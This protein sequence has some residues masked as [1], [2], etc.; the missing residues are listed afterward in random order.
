M[1]EVAPSFPVEAPLGHG[2]M[3]ELQQAILGA[4][5]QIHELTRRIYYKWGIQ[6]ADVVYLEAPRGKVV[7]DLLDWVQSRGRTRELIG[8]LWS[9]N[10]H[11]SDLAVIGQRLL[12]PLEPI[13]A[14]YALARPEAAAAAPVQITWQS[15]E[16][17]V[18]ER[19]R[20]VDFAAFLDRLQ[21]IGKAVCRV[22][23]PHDMGTGFLI[24]RQTV[25]TNYH[26]VETA[27]KTDA[28]G[29]GIGCRFDFTEGAG[30]PGRLAQAA[31]K[32]WLHASSPYSQSDVTGDGEPR[33]TELDF[34]LIRLAAPVEES[35]PALAIDGA[36]P[37]VAPM[38][39]A[40]VVQHP[41]GNPLKLAMGKVLE[42]P[43]SGLRYRYNTTTKGG[44]SGAP[45]FSADFELIGL[46]HAADPERSPRFN[47]AVPIWRVAAALAQAGIEPGAL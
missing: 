8:L 38:D 31:G 12:G 34:A 32:D 10:P 1:S 7:G 44:S 41:D 28:P 43:V 9:G 47:Q 19:S 20:L 33:A 26:V 5:P 35:R 4:Y 39:I 17:I 13:A 3:E 21:R 45:V 16:K 40:I 2:D 37:I 18:T 46:H 24:G 42:F 15:L 6:L 36:P 25:L 27:I 29:T 30:A 11:H 22:E 23:T 14:R